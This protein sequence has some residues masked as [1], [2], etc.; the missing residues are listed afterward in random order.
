MNDQEKPS[1]SPFWTKNMILLLALNILFIL[2]I[3]VLATI[4][5]TA[6][7]ESVVTW[8]QAKFGV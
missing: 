3:L 8:I 1:N 7:G 2:I 5:F 6:L 4:I